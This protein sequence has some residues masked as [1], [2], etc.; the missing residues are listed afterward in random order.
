[1]FFFPDNQLTA[2]RTT[3]YFNEGTYKSVCK[4]EVTKRLLIKIVLIHCGEKNKKTTKQQNTRLLNFSLQSNMVLTVFFSSRTQT[5][6]Y[7]EVTKKTNT[8]Y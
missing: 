3:E 7:L 1:M 4:F 2:P 6:E 5:P 8:P